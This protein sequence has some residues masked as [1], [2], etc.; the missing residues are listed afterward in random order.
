MRTLL[1]ILLL[2]P[3]LARAGGFEVYEQSPAGVG[4][5]GAQA[6]EVDDSAAIYYNPA[7]MAYIRGW[8]GMASVQTVNAVTKVTAPPGQGP[9]SESG[10]WNGIPALYGVQR[11]GSTLAL[12]LGGLPNLVRVFRFQH[13]K[14]FGG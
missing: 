11:I 2:A 13:P 12:G 3:S 8:S 7:K 1:V 14:K 5:A 6:A 10:E 4:T 9:S